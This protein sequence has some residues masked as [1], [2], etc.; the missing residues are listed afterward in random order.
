MSYNIHRGRKPQIDDFV[1]V[2]PSSNTINKIGNDQVVTNCVGSNHDDNNPSMGIKQGD[3]NVIVTCFSKG[4]DRKELLKYFYERL[5]YYI[6]K[7][8]EWE[9]SQEEWRKKQLQK[10]EGQRGR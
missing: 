5:P 2:L 6:K 1:S 3:T 8:E 7:K 10:A 9:K 4:C